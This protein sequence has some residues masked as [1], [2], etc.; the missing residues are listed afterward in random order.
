MWEP[1]TSRTF[2]L[3]LTPAPD[4]STCSTHGS[5]GVD[6]RAGV[7]GARARRLTVFSTVTCQI[8]S[9]LPDLDGAGAGA[10]F[11][12]AIGGVAR[13]EHHEAGV[14]DEAV[15]IFKAPGV[16]IGDQ[17]LSDLVAGQID[18]ARR[19]QQV[20]AAD[21]VVEEQAE[22]QQPGRAQPVMVRQHETKR[23]DDVGRD[24]PED[25][26][27]DQR[28][29]DQ[30]ELV[31][32]Q[33][34]QAAMHELGRPGRRPARQIIHFTKENR[35]SA[36]GRIARDA[37]AIDAAANDGEVENPIA[38]DASPAL[39]LFTLAISLS[40]SIKSQPKAKATEKRGSLGGMTV[41][42]ASERRSATADSARPVRPG[43][44]RT[45]ASPRSPRCR[46][47]GRCSRAPPAARRR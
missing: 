43:Q 1:C 14:I 21:M 12:A 2:A 13:G 18:R 25:F 32:F 27:L 11:G 37:A 16:A 29:A 4:A 28:L 3:A 30:P 20:S 44:P 23:A 7:N 45:W 47:C 9:R 34:A 15:G 40:F 41:S 26:A 19:R 35:I 46:G 36:A 8:P 38:K 33:I 5:A 6:Q 17:R 31:I 24:L 39:R 42:S 22:P 10:D